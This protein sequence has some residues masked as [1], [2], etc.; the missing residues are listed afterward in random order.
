MF[1]RRIIQF[2]LFDIAEEL[3]DTLVS[4][5]IKNDMYVD[6]LLSGCF[7]FEAAFQNQ[8][9]LIAAL[10]TGSLDLRKWTLNKS[11]LIKCLDKYYR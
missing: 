5:K 11:E 7:S 1:L 2:E 3:G 9:D 4:T 8:K 10:K 6:D